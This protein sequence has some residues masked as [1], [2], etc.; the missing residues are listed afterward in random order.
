MR[1]ELGSGTRAVYVAL[2]GGWNVDQGP[3]TRHGIRSELGNGNQWG[4]ERVGEQ[5][6]KEGG[7]E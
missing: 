5:S 3:G 2:V 1:Q 7:S 6:K 4:A